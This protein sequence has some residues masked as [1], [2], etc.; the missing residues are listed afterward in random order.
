[1]I[2]FRL[3]Q[4]IQIYIEFLQRNSYMDPTSNIENLSEFILR[5]MRID[6]K[7]LQRI[8]IKKKIEL[9]LKL[10]ILIFMIR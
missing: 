2:F 7:K 3:F 1:M 5:T 6:R 4:A 9:S 10:K 8:T